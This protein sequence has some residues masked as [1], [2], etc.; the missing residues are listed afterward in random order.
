MIGELPT[1]L[2]VPLYAYNRDLFARRGVTKPTPDG[3]FAQFLERAQQVAVRGQGTTAVYGIWNYEIALD[4]LNVL[5]RERGIDLSAPTPPSL[6]DERYA[7]ALAQVQALAEDGAIL[8]ESSKRRSRTLNDNRSYQ[9]IGQGQVAIWP[10]Q[11]YSFP[12]GQVPPAIG[13]VP[14]RDPATDVPNFFTQGYAIS[15]GTAN[16]E[17]TWRWLSFL[18][19]QYIP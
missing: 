10:A 18:S 6:S 16:P 13:F 5:L 9:L 12:F 7:E 4:A 19:E 1:T 14:M 3:S 8:Y 2:F 17:A 15:A 11:E